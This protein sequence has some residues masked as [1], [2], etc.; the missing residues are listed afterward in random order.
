MPLP[1]PSVRRSV[2]WILGLILAALITYFT[3]AYFDRPRVTIL[4]TSPTVAQGSWREDTLIVKCD[5]TLTSQGPAWAWAKDYLLES[6]SDTL[7]A[8]KYYSM[9]TR[10]ASRLRGMS[11]GLDTLAEKLKQW[12]QQISGE[13]QVE[14]AVRILADDWES[15]V[16]WILHESAL[17]NAVFSQVTP[18]YT[19]PIHH[20]LTEDEDKDFVISFNGKN[21]VVYQSVVS[22]SD[23]EIRRKLQ[24]AARRLAYAVAYGVT[25]DLESI[26]RRLSELTSGR[27][28]GD[29]EV[30]LSIVTRELGLL[31]HL[32]L[33]VVICN[34]GRD[35]TAIAPY[36]MLY[37]QSKNQITDLD[38]SP[39]TVTENHAIPMV[40]INSESPSVV[41]RFP[42]TGSRVALDEP[43]PIEGGAARSVQFASV[44]PLRSLRCSDVL[45][46][47][48]QTR[49]VLC[50][51]A[52]RPVTSHIAQLNDTKPLLSLP[53]VFGE[54]S[55]PERFK[56]DFEKD[57]NW[58]EYP[59][60]SVESPAP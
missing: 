34:N 19:A 15:V 37:V 40:R 53:A 50:V 20:K 17:N 21:L 27:P 3:T 60:P 57:I 52:V 26:G 25:E 29:I 5:R 1:E 55:L 18:S 14:R 35:G 4:I 38:G 8:S 30:L 59:A 58:E 24:A 41:T 10:D 32:S 11:D 23:D 47:L 48:L 44:D 31:S 13:P 42:T 6:Y 36:A 39:Q 49:N 12:P 56:M 51:L 43:I 54:R 16:D 45:L 2:L 33:R 46:K 7:R 28:A 9:L 22:A